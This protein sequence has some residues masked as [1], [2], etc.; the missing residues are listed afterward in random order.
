MGQGEWNLFPLYCKYCT[1]GSVFLP[2]FIYLFLNF[3]CT[4]EKWKK[5]RR[6]FNP[7]FNT[8]VLSK[9]FMDV[10][11]DQSLELVRQLNEHVGTGEHFDLWPYFIERS[12][13]TICGKKK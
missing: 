9:Y 8:A 12:V 2:S 10:F 13:S 4:V 1:Y 5:G 6:L 11:N 7:A 3:N